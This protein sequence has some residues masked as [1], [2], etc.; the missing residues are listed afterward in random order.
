MQETQVRSLGQEDP[1]EEEMAT[2]SRILPW[3]NPRSLVGCSPWGCKRVGHDLA[4]KQQH[5][6][7][8]P[9]KY[10]IC[11]NLGGDPIYIF[12]QKSCKLS[13]N[14][15]LNPGTSR[16]GRRVPSQEFGT[17]EPS[18]RCRLCC[19][20]LELSDDGLLLQAG[21]QKYCWGI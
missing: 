19:P 14:V 16:M 2:H 8:M 10:L 21:I 11:G 5:K 6:Y 13:V 12:L 18:C 7:F 3:K 4:T 1:L 17:D 9:L 15:F 20:G